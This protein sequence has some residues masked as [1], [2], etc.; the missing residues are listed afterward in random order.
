MLIHDFPH[1]KDFLGRVL[2]FQTLAL[3]WIKALWYKLSHGSMNRRSSQYFLGF[4]EAALKSP[5]RRESIRVMG[6][7]VE[8]D[9]AKQE[10]VGGYGGGG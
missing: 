1:Y 9:K 2:T 3:L 6:T 8:V 5:P 10:C 4:R 7:A